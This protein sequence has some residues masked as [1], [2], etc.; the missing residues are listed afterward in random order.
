MHACIHIYN[1]IRILFMS[2]DRWTCACVCAINQLLG[3]FAECKLVFAS[4]MVVHLLPD[5]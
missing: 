4:M 2:Y 1:Y 3:I 5:T